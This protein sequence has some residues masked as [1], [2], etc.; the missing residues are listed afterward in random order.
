MGKRSEQR[1]EEDLTAAESALRLR[2]SRERVVRLIQ[3][4][5]LKGCRHPERGWL[6]NPESLD[7]LT[8]ELRGSAA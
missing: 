3:T 2:M 8:A 1:G 7:Q 6:V 4:G 5:Q